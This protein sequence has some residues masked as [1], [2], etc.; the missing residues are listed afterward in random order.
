MGARKGS[1]RI[2]GQQAPPER[3]RIPVTTSFASS[4][5]RRTPAK[6]CLA[7]SRSRSSGV[8]P[9]Q[10]WPSKA[11]AWGDVTILNWLAEVGEEEVGWMMAFKAG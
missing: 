8:V 1:S 6:A 11:T 2:R 4:N 3:T 7:A 9:W 10:G 5:S